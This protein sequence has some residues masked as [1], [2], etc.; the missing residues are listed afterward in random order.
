[1]GTLLAQTNAQLK[2]QGDEL[3]ELGG[4]ITAFGPDAE[5]I[6]DEFDKLSKVSLASFINGLDD[7]F[8][9]GFGT[10][11]QRNAII[12]DVGVAIRGVS[13]AIA[14]GIRWV[15]HNR[16]AVVAL[17]KVYLAYKIALGAVVVAQAAMVAVGF[18]QAIYYK[19]KAVGGLVAA[20]KIA[21]LWSG[22][23]LVSLLKFVA[24]PAILGYIILRFYHLGKAISANWDKIKNAA[25][26]LGDVIKGH[27]NRIIDTIGK[28]VLSG[29][30]AV[31]SGVN[32]LIN[33]VIDGLNWLIEKANTLPKVNIGTIDAF[34]GLNEV[35]ADVD[36]KMALADARIATTTQN[37]IDAQKAFQT[38]GVEAVVGVAT[39]FNDEMEEIIESLKKAYNT[40]IDG[41][42]TKVEEHAP[43]LIDILDI[44]GLMNDIRSIDL[45]IPAP[46]GERSVNEREPYDFTDAIK[47]AA[48]DIRS[49]LPESDFKKIGTEVVT[50]MG[51]AM[52][53]AL[54]DG[55]WKSLGSTFVSVVQNALIS[56][57]TE[58]AV[59][60]VLKGIGIAHEGTVVPGSPGQE[61]LWKLEGGEVV[62]SAQQARA[63][64]ASMNQRQDRRGSGGQSLNV[65][66]G[67]VMGT[68]FRSEVADVVA[69]RIENIQYGLDDR[70][71]ELGYA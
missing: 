20:M 18:V 60:A 46:P 36:E 68:G 8:G 62:L 24:L 59:G 67:P 34:T 16:D 43:W 39:S 9:G 49:K 54:K 53:D 11:G 64:G 40:V 57:L 66:I 55:D 63:I 2:A 51:S 41:I 45:D 29:T 44:E 14:Q 3:E 35:I 19:I 27:Y 58:K 12:K 38:F 61:S 56:S 30:R 21:V 26:A 52:G 25:S 1:M 65:Q 5:M 50:N 33:S 71:A 6:N 17:V 31:L 69:E 7:A 32:N 15:W 28:A 42:K 22:R 37:I 13:S 10:K 23:L 48:D 47:G 70:Q 4:V